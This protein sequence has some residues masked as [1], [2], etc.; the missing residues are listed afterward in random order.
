MRC[1]KGEKLFLS[2]Y[3]FFLAMSIG[4]SGCY[5][6][7]S[8]NKIKTSGQIAI[9]TDNNANCYYIYRDKPMGFEYDLSKAFADYL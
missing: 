9:I 4:L 2:S 7:D 3:L 5:S 8:L 6:S 1:P